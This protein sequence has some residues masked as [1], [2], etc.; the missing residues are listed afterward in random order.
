MYSA[1]YIAYSY[2]LQQHKRILTYRKCSK[3]FRCRFAVYLLLLLLPLL[4]HTILFIFALPRVRLGSNDVP[5]QQ[6]KFLRV[7]VLF[8]FFFVFLFIWIVHLVYCCCCCCCCYISACS[9][10]YM[11]C[12]YYTYIYIDICGYDFGFCLP[13]ASTYVAVR[14]H[15]RLLAA[16]TSGRK[17]YSFLRLRAC[18]YVIFLSIHILLVA[19]C[20]EYHSSAIP[21]V[22]KFR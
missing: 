5:Q 21:T 8:C 20:S 2:V 7:Y 18:L 1:A 12:M 16:N 10:V 13:P 14:R 19:R 4:L 3:V 9:A 22:W 17:C 11:A 6:H 15:I